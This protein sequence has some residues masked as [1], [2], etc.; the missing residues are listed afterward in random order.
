MKIPVTDIIHVQIKNTVSSAQCIALEEGVPLCMKH[1]DIDV[2]MDVVSGWHTTRQK[3]AE[4]ALS[5][6]GAK[7]PIEVAGAATSDVNV[8]EE[9]VLP[10]IEEEQA[11]KRQKV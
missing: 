10:Q 5:L 9:Q 1:I 2:V 8:G 7:R 6:H 4:P 11:R 3:L